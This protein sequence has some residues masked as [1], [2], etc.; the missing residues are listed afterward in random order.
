MITVHCFNNSSKA[1]D[2]QMKH[3]EEIV[4]AGPSFLLPSSFAA[5]LVRT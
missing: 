3:F 5:E 4:K 1:A 2:E